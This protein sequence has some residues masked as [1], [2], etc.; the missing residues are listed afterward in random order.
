MKKS[1]YG[2]Y[3]AMFTPFDKKGRL[4]TDAIDALVEYG[5]KGGLKGFYLTGSTG[6]GMLLTLEE[7]KEVYRRAVAAAKGL[8]NDLIDGFRVVFKGY[9][10]EVK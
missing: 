3:A 6:E 2:A 10:E 7:R 4:N 8:F 9:R 1:M 5:I